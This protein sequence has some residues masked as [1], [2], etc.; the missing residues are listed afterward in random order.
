MKKG[1][2]SGDI[3]SWPTKQNRKGTIELSP[4][5]SF[6]LHWVLLLLSPLFSNKLF[7]LQKKKKELFW[8]L[9]IEKYA[10]IKPYTNAQSGI[11]TNNPAVEALLMCL[12]NE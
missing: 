10:H 8:S 9:S 3:N 4:M 6:S 5:P 2:R 12:T 11:I 7:N 1:R